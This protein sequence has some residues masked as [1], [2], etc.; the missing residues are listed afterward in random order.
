MDF[1]ELLARHREPLIDRPS[2][3]FDQHTARPK[4][5]DALSRSGVVMLRAALP[6][7][8]LKE[9]GEAF[10]H[11]AKATAAEASSR[12]SW[13]SPWAVR[14]GDFFPAAGVILG[15]LKSWV[16]EVVEEICQSPRIVILLKFCTARHSVDEPLAIG[17][18]QDAKVVAADVPFTFWIP[19]QGIEPEQTSGL[20]FVTRDPGRFL[21]T[22]PHNDVGPDYVLANIHDVWLPRYELGDVS[23]HSR[24]CPHF[25]T[26][27]G[28]LRD[29]FSLEVRAMPEASAPAH[30]LDPAL[31]VARR[32]GIP[33]IVGSHH[34]V[35]SQIEPFLERGRLRPAA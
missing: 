11:F 25:T 3:T 6:P 19:L 18:H 35:A 33:T 28:T 10:R 21:P 32:D 27:F 30:H 1:K 26:G 13:H 20:G 15:L 29:R 16:W 9:S 23:L 7:E 4:I 2:L 24:F 8:R 5:A 14:R 34:T 12:G 31:Y 22:L 17:A